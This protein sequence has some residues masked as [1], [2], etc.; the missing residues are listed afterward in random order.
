MNLLET[1]SLECGVKPSE[2]PHD[3]PGAFVPLPDSYITISARS[4]VPV[5]DYSFFDLVV[6]MIYGECQRNNISILQIGAQDEPPIPGAIKAALNVR[7]SAHCLKHS[8]CHI[9]VDNASAHLA[10]SYGVPIIQ[11]FGPTPAKV[12]GPHHKGE[13]VALE[14]FKGQASYDFASPVKEVDSILPEQVAA[15]I[16]KMLGLGG[17]K[18]KTNFIGQFYKHQSIDFIPNFRPDYN[19]LRGNVTVRMDQNH[20]E[21]IL[22]ET[23]HSRPE[24][25]NI[26]FRKKISANL[27]LDK[28]GGML[29]I[30]NQVDKEFI[31]SLPENVALAYEGPKE[32]LNSIRMELESPFNCGVIRYLPKID[33][34][35]GVTEESRFTTRRMFLS[36][37]RLYGSCWHARQGI[38]GTENILVGKA[39]KSRDFLDYLDNYYIFNT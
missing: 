31:Y 11:L 23:L 19:Q 22:L 4:G 21:Q 33:P 30:F 12:S 9:T 7:Q 10:G 35:E 32:M 24:K 17:V 28:I 1:Y 27:P 5:K 18:I 3:F 20:N 34:P 36:V 39:L 8:L 25:T 29:Y 14:G 2:S 26:I 13:Y 6:S 38:P 16:L 37:G 15:V